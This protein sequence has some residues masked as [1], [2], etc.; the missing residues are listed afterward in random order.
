MTILRIQ[1]LVGSLS[2]RLSRPPDKEHISGNS[3]FLFG[4]GCAAGVIGSFL[5]VL[6]MFSIPVYG[7]DSDITD[8][9]CARECLEKRR[10][11]RS[12]PIHNL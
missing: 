8:F 4:F 11:V 3:F 1:A 5:I 2:L 7:H 10:K 6:K 9:R 12:A